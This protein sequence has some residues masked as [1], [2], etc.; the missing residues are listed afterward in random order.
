MDRREFLSAAALAPFAGGAPDWRALDRTLKGRLVRPGDPSYA[1]AKR[2]FNVAFD[3][4]APRAVA[5]CATAADV[6][7]CVGFARRNGLVVHPRSGGHSYAGWSTG[8]GLIVDVSQLRAVKLTGGLATVGSGAKLIDVYSQ[9]GKSGVSIP[10]GSCPTVGVAGLTLGG[11][12]GVVARRHG[13]TIDVLK[14]VSLVTAD[15]RLIT[16]SANNHPDLF[17]ALRGGGGGNFGIATSFT[18]QTHP[19][20]DVTVFTMRWPWSQ[21]FAVVKKWQKW[22]PAAPD[23]LWSNLHLSQDP[24]RSVSVTGL[25]LGSRSRCEA[26][27]TGFPAS[28]RTV[29]SMG[30]L[31]AMYFMAGCSTLEACHTG[32]RDRFSASSHFAYTEMSDATIRALI[33]QVGRAGRH[34]VLI[35]ALGGAVGR[36]A[37]GATAFP[38][39]KALF[40]LQYYAHFDGASAW[41][42][43]ARDSMT[44]RLGRHAYVNYPDIALKDYKDQY[45]GPNAARLAAV[46]KVYDPTG[47]FRHP[48]GV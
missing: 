14:A 21:A 41:V 24:G 13:L 15:G 1:T 17:W 19:V 3:N 27:L 36:V 18:Y 11:G 22:A 5:Y 16:A 46:K 37:P 44:P 9:L 30:Y 7:A 40:S 45:Y 2:V 4:A 8:S 34:T 12:I 26:L 28:T 20:Q 38:H 10:A 42:R 31:Q 32:P 29:K 47:F 43:S 6:A 35:D 33:A 48:Q 23:A 25:Y 39:R